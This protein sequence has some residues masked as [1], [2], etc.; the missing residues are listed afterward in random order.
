VTN[1]GTFGGLRSN[2]LAINR[3]GKVVG[4]AQTSTSASHAFLWQNGVIKDLGTLGANHS[5]AQGIGPLGQVVG[6]SRVQDGSVHAFVWEN[7]VMSDLGSGVAY[8][9]NRSVWIVGSAQKASG[10]VATL[11]KPN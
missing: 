2:A 6:F 1:L 4:W 8:G 3:D 7:G 5:V 9:V 11:W 10:N